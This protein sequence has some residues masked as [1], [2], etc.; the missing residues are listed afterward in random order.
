VVCEPPEL[1]FEGLHL[2]SSFVITYLRVPIHCRP[3]RRISP[4]FNFFSPSLFYS[5]ICLSRR[6]PNWYNP[7]PTESYNVSLCISCPLTTPNPLALAVKQLL[8][9]LSLLFLFLYSQSR[10]LIS[11]TIS[12]TPF[13]EPSY[14]YCLYGRSLYTESFPLT[15]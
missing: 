4:A 6:L 12:S 11:L 15:P 8:S 14:H 5:S 7:S 2:C 10:I 9:L 13:I 3:C 1:H